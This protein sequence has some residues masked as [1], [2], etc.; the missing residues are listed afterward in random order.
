[1]N[2]NKSSKESFLYCVIVQDP[3]T[4]KPV[5]YAFFN[6]EPEAME[7]M[8]K[9]ISSGRFAAVAKKRFKSKYSS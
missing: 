3:L 5:E 4:N 9:I 1:M 2:T 7:T 8:S 6:S